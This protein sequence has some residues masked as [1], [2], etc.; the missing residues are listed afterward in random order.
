MLSDTSTTITA[1][2]TDNAEMENNRLRKTLMVMLF[3]RWMLLNQKPHFIMDGP[4]FYEV[5]TGDLL[6]T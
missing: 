5:Y 2:T 4:P 6:L 1:Q 3:A